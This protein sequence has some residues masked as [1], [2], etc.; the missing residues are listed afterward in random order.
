MISMATSRREDAVDFTGCGRAA[1]TR[2]R[3]QQQQQAVAGTTS[4]GEA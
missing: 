3:Q 2:R 1:L 4:R